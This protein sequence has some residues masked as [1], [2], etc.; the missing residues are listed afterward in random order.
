MLA[1]NR[2][3]IAAAFFVSGF[4]ALLLQVTWQRVL[5]QI[6]GVDSVAIA[7]IVTIFLLGLG[8]GSLL[9]VRFTRGKS[10]RALAL[11]YCVIEIAIGL[12]G[13]VSIPVLRRVNALVASSVALPLLG[14]F[15]LNLCLLLVPTFLMGLTTPLIV[16]LMKRDLGD[17][18]RTVGRYYGL[19]ILGGAVGA[20]IGGLVLIEVLGLTGTTLLAAS[21]NAALGVVVLLAAPQTSSGP[22]EASNEDRGEGRV[23]P[24]L[25]AAVFLFGFATLNLQLALVRVA[26]NYFTLSPITFSIALSVFLLLMAGGQVL[27]GHLVDRFGVARIVYPMCA[28]LAAGVAA[29][30]A[31]LWVEPAS[32]ARIGAYVV[33]PSFA[34]LVSPEAAHI[35]TDPRLVPAI[36]LCAIIMSCI[37]PFSSFF[38]MLVR[39]ATRSIERAGSVTA[40]MLAA[41][42]L[43]NVVG[44]FLTGLVLPGAIGT[45]GA[46]LV[47][48]VCCGAAI[49]LTAATLRPRGPSLV[50]VVAVAAAICAVAGAAAPRDYFKRFSVDR[51][52]IADAIEGPGGVISVIP[53]QRFF[54]LLAMY[55]T[56]SG[57][58]ITKPPVA[59]DNYQAWRVNFS[60]LLALSPGP[61]PKRILSI[62]LGHALLARALLDYPFVEKIVVVE[63]SEELRNLVAAHSHEEIRRIFADPRVEIVI[64]DGRR[65]MQKALQRGERFDMVEIR[66]NEPWRAGASSL[67]TT[68]AFANVRELLEPTGFL[69]VRP[70]INHIATA[71]RVFP[72][73]IWVDGRAYA[74]FGA[75]P[76]RIPERAEARADIAA[77]LRSTFPGQG[78]GPDESLAPLRVHHLK[79][80]QFASD[81]VNT[82]D[83]PVLE[84]NWLRGSERSGDRKLLAASGRPV[85][86]RTVP[87]D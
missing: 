68:D 65:Y 49:V 39:I 7:F 8:A 32:F 24:A 83:H 28:V 57:L 55:R 77:A 11:S 63:I 16:Q 42:T 86:V 10:A 38:P 40:A 47:A 22:A 75:A 15:L 3:V 23:Q 84:F 36:L 26:A 4:S 82:D 71:L 45:V 50:P 52:Q 87:F 6:I 58:A 74:F 25:L 62:G 67:F 81:R 9:G 12:C 21:L 13:A 44:A 59:T 60:E 73:G 35:D 80:A 37:V 61:R 51:L 5:T 53:T 33:S 85:P 72:D 18:G 76:V 30:M 17:L 34:S 70:M 1:M 43:G 69:V 20:L 66:I 79:P 14:D 78:Q 48:I 54:T 64:Q 46:M 2:S 41:A 31:A 56:E 29:L 19:N 27:G